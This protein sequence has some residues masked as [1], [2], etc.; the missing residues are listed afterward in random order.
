MQERP[1]DPSLQLLIDAL[2]LAPDNAPLRL[3]VA[4][5]LEQRAQHRQALEHFARLYLDPQHGVTAR[6]GAGRCYLALGDLDGAATQLNALLDAVPEHAMG[7]L[8]RARVYEKKRDHKAARRDYERAV[9][10]DPGLADTALWDALVPAAETAE[11]RPEAAPEAPAAGREAVRFEQVG[12]LEELKDRIRMRIIHPFKRPELFQ[13]YGKRAGGGILFY[14]PPGCGKTFLARATAGECGAHFLSVGLH[15]VLDMWIGNSEKQ[16]HALFDEARRRAP[17]VLFFDEVDAL[18]VQRSKLQSGA[19]RG[20]IT[21]FLSELDGFASKNDRVLVIGA[22][23]TPWDLDSAFRRPGR[24]DQVLFVPPPDAPARGQILRLK[25]KDKPQQALDVERIAALTEGF[26]GADLE[27]LVE[28]ATELAIQQ[29]MRSGRIEPL[30]MVMLETARARLKP[31]TR[32]WFQTA[33]NYAQ[34]SNEGGQYDE[35]AD[36]LRRAKL[37]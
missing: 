32:E 15:E 11:A 12:G 35:I 31:T 3:H 16:L 18:G 4:A 21:Q 5:S 1:V 2:G 19:M 14:G 10:L 25:L 37:V 26:S 30:T 27:H 33:K 8:L 23:N 9:S 17:S 20:V 24:F 6:L 22:T 28:S 13:A 29:A 7:L 34:Y 36:Y